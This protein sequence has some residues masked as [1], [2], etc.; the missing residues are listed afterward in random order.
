MEAVQGPEIGRETPAFTGL[1]RVSDST[2]SKDNPGGAKP[3]PGSSC[4]S[5]LALLNYLSYM[6]RAPSVT[7]CTCSRPDRLP[8]VHDL[9]SSV[10]FC[11]C[12]RPDRLPFV[13]NH[14]SYLLP[15]STQSR[16][17]AGAGRYAAEDV[18]T[19]TRAEEP[20]CQQLLPRYRLTAFS[21]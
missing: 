21:S 11:T 16:P 7:F 9:A 8:F 20:I 10:T 14:L 15:C 6:F 12:C 1:V 18:N 13:H 17:E 19:I 4:V 2:A 5:D 3:P